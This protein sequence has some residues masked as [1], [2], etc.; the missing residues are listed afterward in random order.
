MSDSAAISLLVVVSLQCFDL[1]VAKFFPTVLVFEMH[2]AVLLSFVCFER[3][4]CLSG[5]LYELAD[6]DSTALDPARVLVLSVCLQLRKSP[7]STYKAVSKV[8]VAV[9]FGKTNGAAMICLTR[10]YAVLGLRIGF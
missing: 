10:V 3:N 7:Q 9:L 2:N 6:G 4:I 1:L 5:L 8:V